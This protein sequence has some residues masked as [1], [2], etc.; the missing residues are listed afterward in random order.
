MLD[1][2]TRKLIIDCDPGIDDAI[3]LCMALF[4]P[5][6]EV[7]AV[8]A[9]AG[10]ID[11]DRA[12]TNVQALLE[13][14][15]P[16][17]LPR[18]GAASDV[19]GGPVLDDAELHGPDGLAGCN[20]VCSDRQHRPASEKVIAELVRMY[21][22]EVT[23]VCLGPLTN[24]AKAIQRD[25]TLCD[26]I[27]KVLISGGAVGA[28]GNVTAAAEFNMFFD[29]ASARRVFHSPTTKSLVPLDV[30]E[31]L[32]FGMDLLDELPTKLSRVG[33]ILHRLLPFAFRA[34]HLRLGRE[35][36]PL[37]DPIAL[38]A[39]I[40]PDL[41]EWQDMAGD[42]ET[43]GQLCRG[44]TVFDRRQRPQ[45]RPNMEVAVQLDAAEVKQQILRALRFA[46][47]ESAS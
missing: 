41:F 1:C 30:T 44:A 20:F 7:L 45:G 11:A 43:E 13:R 21:P 33:G 6:L 8:T 19:E 18:L 14:L 27:H 17:R 22:N 40:E 29:P 32:M 34:Q 5:R 38:I 46:G 2:M 37:Y 9:T 39:A 26:L 28:P 24:L 36:L 25:P 42:V 31:R 23:I 3:A 10:T 47:Q 16:P 12:T 35:A 4:D 15:D